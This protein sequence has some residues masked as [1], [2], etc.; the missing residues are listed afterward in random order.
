MSLI[1]ISVDRKSLTE[2]TDEDFK[3][4]VEYGIE[5]NCISLDN[6]LCDEDLQGIVREI[7]D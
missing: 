5:R 3:E 4:W 1:V 6:P 2:H 7:S